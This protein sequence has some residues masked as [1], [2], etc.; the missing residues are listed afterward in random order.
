MNGNSVAITLYIYATPVPMAINVN[1]FKFRVRTDFHPRTKKGAPPHK[2]TGVA[3]ANSIHDCHE[4]KNPPVNI[5]P[6]VIINNGSAR[7]VLIQNRLV[8][9]INSG[10]S[11]SSNEISIG[12]RAIPQMGQ[13]SNLSA[14]TSGCMGHVYFTFAPSGMT[15]FSGFL[16][17]K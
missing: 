4:P 8:M 12:S 17:P 6:I 11:V 1:I 3:N 16:S 7:A 5:P 15:G 14:I 10:F 2:T 13:S 9:S